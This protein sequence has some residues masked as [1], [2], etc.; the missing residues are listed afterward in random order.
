MVS[1]KHFEFKVDSSV[2]RSKSLPLLLSLLL[3]NIFDVYISISLF[4]LTS[5]CFRNS[6]SFS[7]DFTISVLL[8][9]K[10]CLLNFNSSFMKILIYSKSSSNSLDFRASM[11]P[12]FDWVPLRSFPVLPS[13]NHLKLQD[14]LSK[15]GFNSVFSF[16]FSSR[17]LIRFSMKSLSLSVFTFK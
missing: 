3:P 8:L 15:V 14:Q 11:R 9:S 10:P 13:R 5:S 1:S 4:L 6:S 12:S 17:Y 7:K 2:S 16:P